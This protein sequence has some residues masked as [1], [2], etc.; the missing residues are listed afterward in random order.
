MPAPTLR[1]LFPTTAFQLDVQPTITNFITRRLHAH[2]V[3]PCWSRD[4]VSVSQY[5]LSNIDHASQRIHSHH[6]HQFIT[7]RHRLKCRMAAPRH[8][9]S[10][11]G[12]ID[13]GVQQVVF[14]HGS[15]RAR[16]IARFHR[17]VAHFEALEPPRDSR[18]PNMKQ[19][20]R[21]AL[22]RLTFEYAR[23]AESQDR[24][25][26]FFFQSLAIDML[27]G[28]ISLDADLRESL[29]GVAEFLMTNFF[30]P[31]ASFFPLLFC[32]P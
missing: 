9:S 12:L 10:L 21:P 3:L 32:C 2:S 13:C 5:C 16:A 11:E 30:L 1:K 14:S 23:S 20:N 19:Y 31:R 18:R 8:Q 4:A 7:S 25:L 29:F 22:V 26:S 15:E 28:T 6:H 27:E 24:F 17:I